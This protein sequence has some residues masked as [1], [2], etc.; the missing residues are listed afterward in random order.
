MFNYR[1]ALIDA[2][3]Y[4]GQV[5]YEI[6]SYDYYFQQELDQTPV[7]NFH[8]NKKIHGVYPIFGEKYEYFKNTSEALYTLFEK[9]TKERH[10]EINAGTDN[11]GFTEFERELIK[12]TPKSGKLIRH[13][14]LDA[15]Y[16]PSYNNLKILECNPENPG[17]IWDNDFAVSCMAR[18][19][20][21]L[22]QGV[23]APDGDFSTI[24]HHKQKEQ[25]LHSI[26]DA[27]QTMHGRPPKT[28]AIGLFPEDDASFIAHC[29]A[30]YFRACGYDSLIVNPAELHYR[31]NK[32]YAGDT[33][34]DVLFRGFLMEEVRRHTHE[35]DH[36][37]E[38][39]INNDLCVVP[40]F[41]DALINSKTLMA[42]VRT[43]YK[44]LLTK[45]EEKLI[46]ALFPEAEVVTPDNYD[47]IMANLM[48]LVVKAGEGYGGFGVIVGR[49]SLD[50]ELPGKDEIARVPYVAQAYFPHE[51]IKAPYFNNGNVSVETVNVVLGNLVILG[52]YTGTLVRGSLS[53]VINT[54]Q[55]AEILTSFDPDYRTA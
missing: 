2:L 55:G 39:Y 1:Q 15:I 34:I 24:K 21:K 13:I 28:I 38:A 10:K 7:P 44:H 50:K 53:D 45:K 36:M 27:H 32:V 14:R 52:K 22:Y 5:K 16:S 46:D 8:L 25:L 4:P 49:Q 6:E 54:H 51:T 29:E 19:M 41:S 30:N 17:G 37:A 43:R 23:F 11:F 33:Q 35:V 12:V 48:N 31:D 40:P 47:R 9:L 18:N 3:R 26:V 20:T 42:E